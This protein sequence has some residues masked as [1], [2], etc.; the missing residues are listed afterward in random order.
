MRRLLHFGLFILILLA[1]LPAAAQNT[2]AAC[3]GLP[4]SRLTVGGWGRVTPTEG[5]NF[6]RDSAHRDGAQLASIG[7]GEQFYV[8]DGPVCVDGFAWWLI[9]YKTL[10][11]WTAEGNSDVYWLEPIEDQPV[12]ST[13]SR[14]IALQISM[15]LTRE[16]YVV[17]ADRTNFH[18]LVGADN[19]ILEFEWSPDGSQIAY[20]VEVDDHRSVIYLLPVNAEG[21]G[22]EPRLLVSEADFYGGMQWSPDGIQLGFIQ[23]LSTRGNPEDFNWLVYDVESGDQLLKIEEAGIN[24]QWSPDGT[25]LV[26]LDRAED[27]RRLFIMD[28][29]G[30]NRRAVIEPYANS[31]SQFSWSPDGQRI[32]FLER[33]DDLAVKGR[34]HT[35]ELATGEVTTLHSPP[36]T[37]FGL[38]WSADGAEMLITRVVNDDINVYALATDGSGEMRKVSADPRGG[39]HSPL[40]SPDGESVIYNIGHGVGEID[41]AMVDAQG[42]DDHTLVQ[43]VLHYEWRP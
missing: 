19:Y 1:A 6:V 32:A 30:Q 40:W 8:A 29:D 26:Y 20:R 3:P 9:Q 16:I 28:A 11:G 5:A 25:Q 12:E 39:C 14:Q 2:T 17:N 38:E 37:S 41:L 35:V 4:E 23:A 15:H 18:K 7:P 27:T 36:D 33:T 24:P 42:G 43:Y 21:E 31:I 13:D 34:I 22:G 10:V